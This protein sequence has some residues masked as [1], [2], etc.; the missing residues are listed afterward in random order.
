M[1]FHADLFS[2]CLQILGLL[3]LEELHVNRSGLQSLLWLIVSELF[4][5]LVQQLLK[6]RLPDRDLHLLN[7]VLGFSFL[8][9]E[10]LLQEV[11]FVLEQL[12]DFI[13]FS[14]KNR[15]LFELSL[16]KRNGLLVLLFFKETFLVLDAQVLEDL[17]KNLE[18]AFESV[19]ALWTEPDRVEG[20]KN[21]HDIFVQQNAHVEVVFLQLVGLQGVVHFCVENLSQFVVDKT[22]LVCFSPEALVPGLI[23]NRSK[24]FES[25]LSNF[26][27]FRK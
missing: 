21:F 14:H 6:L 27:A 7:L 11:Y 25:F 8:L 2:N 26:Q 13:L 17:E 15:G 16:K 5:R 1:L 18:L 3:K 10:G 20:S 19:S 24:F 23:Q 9:L 12:N 22:E 4:V